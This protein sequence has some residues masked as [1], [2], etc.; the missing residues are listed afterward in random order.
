MEAKKF[1]EH[2]R[3][4]F[5]T[6]ESLIHDGAPGLRESGN[7]KTIGGT[8]LAFEKKNDRFVADI[9]EKY[10][11]EHDLNADKSTEVE[12]AFINIENDLITMAFAFGYVVGQTFDV[13]Y[14]EIQKEIE[15]VK[16][17]LREKALFPYLPREV[18]ERRAP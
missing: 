9:L 16:S 7:D 15:T 11:A 4:I 17:F 8:L 13:G 12:K 5:G 10:C 14:P 3:N 2:C 1:K 18:K 6:F